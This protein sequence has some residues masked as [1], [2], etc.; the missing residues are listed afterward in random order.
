MNNPLIVGIKEM[1][2]NSHPFP[3]LPFFKLVSFE[4][5]DILKSADIFVQNN[6]IEQGRKHKKIYYQYIKDSGK[7]YLCV[8][9]PV[10]R[11]NMLLHPHPKSYHRWS[12]TSY[13]R[14]E[15]DYNNI[16]CSPD[17]WYTIKKLQNIQI[18]DWR[19]SGDYILLIM[20]RPGDSSLKNLFLKYN[21][22]ENFL[23]S[24]I[25]Q[26]RKHTDRPIRLRLH[27]A[28]QTLQLRMLKNINLK[29]IEI[30]QNMH[31]IINNGN[32]E[33]GTGLY[34]DFKN[35]RAVV[36]FNSNALTESICEGI[37]T[38]SMCN[39]SMAWECSNHDLSYLESE[40]SMDRDQWLANLGYCQWTLTETR[41][42]EPWYHLKSLYKT[43]YKKKK[44]SKL[45]VYKSNKRKHIR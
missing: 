3:Q 20:Q 44:P 1:Y 38:F 29:N 16:N 32:K 39:S 45:K 19:Y 42:G 43:K 28:K 18:K 9:A 6:I 26:I 15:G 30:S 2:K 36:G 7:P 11:R 25:K 37:P 5:K 24:T 31:G 17:R 4:D 33:G 12:W 8:E 10:F 34:E 13:L 23:S 27:P 35:A 14:N 21:S 40:T 22:Y 41:N